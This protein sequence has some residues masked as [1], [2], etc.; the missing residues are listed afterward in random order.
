MIELLVATQGTTAG[1]T[2]AWLSAGIAGIAAVVISIV[3]LLV[4]LG[5]NVATRNDVNDAQ[6]K[7]EQAIKDADGELGRRIDRLD[8]R[9]GRRIDRLDDKIDELKTEVVRTM[10]TSV[11][12]ILA[13]GSNVEE[14]KDPDSPASHGREQTR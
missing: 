4:K 7:N 5:R 11:G 9:L 10:A 14:E 3:V 6:A 8:D 12:I 2:P 13:R 1:S